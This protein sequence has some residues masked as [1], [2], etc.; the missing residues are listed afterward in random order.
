MKKAIALMASVGALALTTVAPTASAQ[1]ISICSQE[2]ITQL[3][4]FEFA[5]A[6]SNETLSQ[7]QSVVDLSNL[8][9]VRSIQ[10]VGH[11]DTVGS[12]AANQRL[13]VR[14]ANDVKAE[15]VKMGLS[16]DLISTS[17]RG[18]LEPFIPTA[19]NVK[20]QL[21]RRVEVLM[22]LE[23]IVFQQPAEPVYVEPEPVYVE[24]EPV[25]VE[26]EPVYVQPEP[27]YV[28]PAPVVPE[29]TPVVQ[30]PTPAPS[31]TPAPVPAT[32]GG[33]SNGLL[34]AGAAAA[35]GGLFLILDDD[36]PASP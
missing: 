36:T 19:D 31:P 6:Q 10:L 24:P 30:A 11:T 25:Y 3:V 27:V 32:V 7:M 4:Y 1:D 15:L 20:E 26:P 17:G 28:E 33:F 23:P 8:C 9:T 13:S 18:E 35:A 21:N 12:T 14:R 22:T 16:S 2:S 29:P 34:L 5:K